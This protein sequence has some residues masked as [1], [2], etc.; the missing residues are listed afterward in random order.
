MTRKYQTSCN[1]SKHMDTC[2]YNNN[3]NIA[4]NDFPTSKGHAEIVKWPPL[5]AGISFS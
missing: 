3:I 5:T 4:L 2:L 1:F